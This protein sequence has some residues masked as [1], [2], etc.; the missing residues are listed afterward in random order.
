MKVSGVHTKASYT[1]IPSFLGFGQSDGSLRVPSL[2]HTITF[3]SGDLG[4]TRAM[5]RGLRLLYL[6]QYLC[7]IQDSAQVLT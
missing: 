6:C 3:P 4:T 2:N 7:T 5:L 1:K